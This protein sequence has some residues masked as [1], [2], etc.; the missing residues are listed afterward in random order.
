MVPT[1]YSSIQMAIDTANPGDTI[2]VAPGTYT[3]SLKITKPLSLIGQ[4]P[5]NTII[6]HSGTAVLVNADNVEIRGF[7]VKDGTYGIFLWYS[8]GVLLRNNVMTDNKW[9][10]GVWGDSL[11]HFVHDVDTSN[12][13]DKKPI[14]FWVDQHSKSLPN[15][16][17][18]VA[19]VNSTKITVKNVNPTSNEQ[20]V[21]L[22]NTKDSV[23]ENVT[24]RGNDQGIVLRMANNNTVKMANLVSINFDA[25]YLL[26]SHNN[27]FYENTVN[28]GTNAISLTHSNNNLFYH[29]N[30]FHN[31]E[32]VGSINS[33]NIWNDKGEG[34]YWSNYVGKDLNG[35]GIGDT[36]LPHLG[37]DYYPLV[38]IYDKIPPIANAGM[39]QTVFRNTPVLLNA[40]GSWDNI[41]I[42]S[43]KWDFGDGSNS[44]DIAIGHTYTAVGDFEVTLNV[45]DMA[46]N[47]AIDVIK[48]TVID[49][50]M[51]PTSWILF[52]GVAGILF[53][54][55]LLWMVKYTR[56]KRGEDVGALKPKVPFA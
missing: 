11:S 36:G 37:V 42:I 51:P 31:K 15:D 27:I 29:N 39:D 56:K 28:N 9:N 50:P 16:A 12:I 26:N 41:A 38:N 55:G 40:S 33:S 45:T 10:F 14:Y 18:Y 4:G 5:D 2:N 53:L 46:G 34:N 17:G 22:V 35:D 20:G 25:I 54:A 43:Y 8:S 7:T 6:A 32:Q 3:E 49:P 19:L 23:I 1:D 48:I 21:L 47:S 44:T 30:F 13:A 52:L 24:M